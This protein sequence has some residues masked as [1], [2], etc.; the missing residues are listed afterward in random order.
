MISTE[1]N[2]HGLNLPH[3][4]DTQKYL[5]VTEDNKAYSPRGVQSLFQE[6]VA[7][8]GGN[9][10]AVFAST[11]KYKQHIE[12]WYASVLAILVYKSTGDKYYMYPSDSPDVHFIKNIG[13]RNQE[14]F[15]VEIMTLFN[16]NM[17]VFDGDYQSLS[18][19]VWKKKGQ[20]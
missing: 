18:E 16:Y 14:G 2:E 5:L 15:S 4:G 9:I 12:L 1:N 13:S 20:N 3:I 10:Q 8:E 17:G 7:N 19:S 6:A 11:N